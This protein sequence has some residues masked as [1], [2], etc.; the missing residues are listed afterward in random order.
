MKSRVKSAVDRHSA[1]PSC[2]LN[3]KFPSSLVHV[4]LAA[5]SH[6]GLVRRRNQDHYLAVR[7]GRSLE[8][9]MTN[10]ADGSLARSFDETAY[11]LLVADGMG[12]MAAGEVASSIALLTLVELAVNTPDWS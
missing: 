2:S 3:P 6:P 7:I 4:G 8:T 1:K 9:L 5:R 12:G 10:L 11:G